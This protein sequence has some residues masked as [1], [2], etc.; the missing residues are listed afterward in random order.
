[1]PRLLAI[2][3]KPMMSVAPVTSQPGQYA[4]LT[5]ALPQVVMPA[6]LPASLAYLAELDEV[7]V[8]QEVELMKI[9][10]GFEQN[11]KYTI[12]NNQDM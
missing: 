3:V 11:N 6:G 4:P 12:C 10:F 2:L 7:R 9:L 1:M 5:I 8:H